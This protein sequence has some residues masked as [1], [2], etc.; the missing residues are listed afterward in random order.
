M[1]KDIK[2]KWIA[3][4]RS[5]KYKQGRIRLRQR[6]VVSGLETHCCLGVLCDI[7]APELWQAPYKSDD[8][9]IYPVGGMMGTLPNAV[10]DALAFNDRI[11]LPIGL[12]V[13][14]IVTNRFNHIRA[15]ADLNDADGLT[16]EQIADLV[17]KYVAGIERPTLT[18]P[19]KVIPDETA[20]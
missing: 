4:L 2:D 10:E 17:E 18:V 13:G 9:L 3:A 19:I 7:T 8:V 12:Q 11:D 15:Y 14:T 16:F 20:I 6:N 1:Y 5:G